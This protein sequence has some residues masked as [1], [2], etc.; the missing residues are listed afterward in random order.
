MRNFI[1]RVVAAAL[2]ASI[3]AMAIE[4]YQVP[5]LV[6]YWIGLVSGA[7]ILALFEVMEGK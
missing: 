4:Y 3:P 7:S 2:L 5:G 1:Y 6:A